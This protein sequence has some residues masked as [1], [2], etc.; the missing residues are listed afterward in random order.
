MEKTIFPGPQGPKQFHFT[1]DGQPF[2]SHNQFITGKQI[3]QMAG[4]AEN[5]ELYLDMPHGWQDHYVRNED[6]I[7]LGRPGTEHFITLKKKTVIFVNGT[8]YDY[9]KEKVSFE[10]IVE[11]ARVPA[12][13]FSG[14][15]VKYSNGPRQNPRGMMSPGTEVFVCNKMDFNV[16]S[17]HQS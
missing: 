9:D 5:V 2:K 3:R 14:Y 10:K 16:R 7:D 17:T 15:I 11:L 13:G 6:R 1:V 12:H 8:P 4:L